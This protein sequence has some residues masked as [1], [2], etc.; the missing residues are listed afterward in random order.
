MNDNVK[1]YKNNSGDILKVIEDTCPD[2]SVNPMLYCDWMNY[3]TWLRRHN[4]IHDQSYR[5]IDD[6]FDVQVGE[7]AYYKLQEK[8]TSFKHFL[9]LL[10]SA[11]D[12]V[13]IVAFPI[14][15]YEHSAIT[16]YLGDSIDRWDGSL[17]GFAWQTKEK[18]YK[19]YKC[20]RISSK[21]RENIKGCVETELATYTLYCNGE[22]Y[23]FELYDRNGIELD[24]AY[25][26]IADGYEEMLE[27]TIDDIKTIVD[28]ID[29]V[30]LTE[31][32]EKSV[33]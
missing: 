26:F 1:Y 4:S 25:G 17:A 28:D 8:A 30:E 9:E 32:M 7:D 29:F 20:K 14:L 18:L 15:S 21:I 10:T 5:E 12:K 23:D 19:N 3:Y 2:D 13:G 16:Y 22:I 6:W 24:C 11:L 33:A 31:E 27:C